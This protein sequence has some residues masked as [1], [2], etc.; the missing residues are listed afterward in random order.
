MGVVATVLTQQVNMC[1]WQRWR[2]Y[3]PSASWL[4]ISVVFLFT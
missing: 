1:I 3:S 4:H 2:L